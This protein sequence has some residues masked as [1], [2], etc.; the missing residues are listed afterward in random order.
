MFGAAPLT[1]RS[2]AAAPRHWAAVAE[3]RHLQRGPN[4]AAHAASAVFTRDKLHPSSYSLLCPVHFD[5]TR[6]PQT[7]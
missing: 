6:T 4:I 7:M 2:A 1:L 5:V 3:R